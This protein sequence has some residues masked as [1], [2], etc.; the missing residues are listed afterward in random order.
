LDAAG[1]PVAPVRL[2]E[3]LA[4]DEQVAADGMIWELEHTVTGP[5]RVV[6]PWVTMS[7]TPTRAYRAAPALGEHS[8]DLL[9][10]A[11]FSAEDI[12]Q[13]CAEGVVVQYASGGVRAGA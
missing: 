13:L 3:E 9:A 4:D 5:Q 2:P 6:G 7:K 1:A 8:A 10:E 12:E 11:G